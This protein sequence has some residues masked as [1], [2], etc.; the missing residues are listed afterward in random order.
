M[1][2]DHYCTMERIA[3]EMTEESILNTVWV[4][5]P[6]WEQIVSYC[7]RYTILGMTDMTNKVLTLVGITPEFV[8]NKVEEYGHGEDSPNL[9]IDI[10]FPVPDIQKIM[11]QIPKFS[12]ELFNHFESYNEYYL[13][14][15]G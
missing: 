7:G 11:K 6:R 14:Y 2:K 13:M 4:F 5:V 1:N 9:K 10:S 12:K 8:Y 3:E 15:K